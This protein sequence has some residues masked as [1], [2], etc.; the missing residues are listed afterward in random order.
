MVQVLQKKRQ[1]AELNKIN[2]QRSVAP[3]IDVIDRKRDRQ[4]ADRNKDLDFT[5]KF[6]YFN[7]SNKNSNAA[8]T[9]TNSLM[10]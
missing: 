3:S 4:I 7:Y 9:K 2:S 6:S 8:S 5:E 1:L 10:R